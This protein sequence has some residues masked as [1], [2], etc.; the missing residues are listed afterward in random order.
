M[1]VRLFQ[2]CSFLL[3][4]MAVCFF[5]L[6]SRAAIHYV[7]PNGTGTGASWEE[8]GPLQATVNAAT[9]GDEVWVAAGT[10]R[11]TQNPV[12]IMKG[13][14]A[15]Y[16]GFAG[17]EESVEQ[18]DWIANPAVIDGESVRGC[19]RGA[20]NARLDGFTV[21]NGKWT[22]I[23]GGMSN[24]AVSPAVAN[25][26]FFGNWG[27]FGGAI[28]NN[29]ASPVITDCV[30]SNNYSDWDGGGMYNKMSSPEVSGCL[31]SGNTS[32]RRGGGM[33]NS[34]ALPEVSD[35]IFVENS[36]VVSGGGMYNEESAPMVSH[37]HFE[38]NSSE[39]GGGMYICEESVPTVSYCTFNLNVAANSGGGICNIFSSPTLVGCEILDNTVNMENGNG[40]GI[41][42]SGASLTMSNCLLAGNSAQEYGGG[43]YNEISTALIITN[44]TIT[45]NM[46]TMERGGG[47]YNLQ[48]EPEITNCILWNN[49]S[50]GG[51]MSNIEGNPLSRVIFSCI[52]GGYEGTGNID[53]DPLFADVS[54][55]DF[56]LQAASL[57]IDT[58]TDVNAPDD[59]IRGIPRPQGSGYDMGAYEYREEI[60]HPADVDVNYRMVMSEVISYLTGWQQGTNPMTNAIRAVYLWQVG[61]FYAYNPE[62]TPPLC[63]VPAQP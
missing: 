26:T 27:G 30:F 54:V 15:L 62:N 9:A 51:Q 50:S 58:G 23:G 10:Y 44:C 33:Y 46:T 42:N 36:S 4:L 60:P 35:C 31:F 34:A 7:K 55:G 8:A 43:I 19:V 1:A 28:Y 25:C 45:E 57:C 63:W 61:E 24:D 38:G 32:L 6:D 29:N 48:S 47:I 14:V 21:T 40:G 5:M 11:S 13:G 39:R 53:S 3:P 52:G 20:D 16:G 56:R 17:M 49:S 18:R 59:D 37:C 41:T 12:L 2:R 22:A